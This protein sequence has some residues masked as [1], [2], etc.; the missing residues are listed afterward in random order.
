LT[1]PASSFSTFAAIF[2]SSLATYRERLAGVYTVDNGRPAWDPVR[3]LGGLD[4]PPAPTLVQ[5][6]QLKILH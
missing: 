4:L 1:Q 3:L 2:S 5:S 6:W